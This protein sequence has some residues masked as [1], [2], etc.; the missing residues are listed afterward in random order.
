MYDTTSSGGKLSP[1]QISDPLLRVELYRKIRNAQLD[2]KYRNSDEWG[3][4]EI[5]PGDVLSPELIAYKVYSLD[6]LKW[7]VMI[8]AGLDDPRERLT[9]GAIIHLPTTGWLYDRIKHYSELASNG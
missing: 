1:L 9:S 3:Y 8:A 2:Q 6:A 5:Q 7:V 4:Y